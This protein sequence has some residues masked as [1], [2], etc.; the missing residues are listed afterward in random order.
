MTKRFFAFLVASGTAA[1][2]NVGARYV[3][4]IWLPYLTS[5]IIAYLIGMTVAFFLNRAFVFQ[6]RHG[7]RARQAMWFLAVNVLA[8]MQTAII[9]LVLARWLLPALSIPHADT[10]AHMIGVAAPAIT[11]FIA[12]NLL[13]FRTDKRAED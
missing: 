1:A 4:D 3:L 7:S 5:I 12:H 9:S 2:C 8:I 6:D 13:T 10:V 11:S